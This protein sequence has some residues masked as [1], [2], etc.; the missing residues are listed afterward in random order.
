MSPKKAKLETAINLDL[1]HRAEQNKTSKNDRPHY[2]L[3][4]DR[5]KVEIN[6]W[7]VMHLDNDFFTQSLGLQ[8][9]PQ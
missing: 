5:G 3:K 4:R 2:V 1:P 7:I 9:A 6:A 8:S